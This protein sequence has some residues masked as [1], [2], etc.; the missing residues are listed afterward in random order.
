MKGESDQ[1]FEMKLQKKYGCGVHFTAAHIPGT[2][3]T[4][5]DIFLEN[6]LKLLNGNWGLTCLKNFYAC[7]E[8]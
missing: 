1:R 7:L 6:S 4:E 2:Q 5:V 3:N 8:T